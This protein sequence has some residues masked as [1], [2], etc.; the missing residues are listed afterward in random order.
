MSG[1]FFPQAFVTGSLQ[2]YARKKS[3][4]I[5]KVNF[6]FKFMDNVT[7]HSEIKEKPQFGCY[8]Y[9]IFIEGCRWSETTHTLSESRPKELFS[10]LP[11]M[12]LIPCEDNI[13]LNE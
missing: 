9:G 6:K 2:N 11:I 10:Q 3:I 1:F 4:A 12:H 13:N 8:I 5:D 7:H